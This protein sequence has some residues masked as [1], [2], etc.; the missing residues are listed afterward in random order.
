MNKEEE[1]NRKK[2]K[3]RKQIGDIVHFFMIQQGSNVVIV[4]YAVCSKHSQRGI[5]LYI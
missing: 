3:S 1:E 4:F 2:V 5:A